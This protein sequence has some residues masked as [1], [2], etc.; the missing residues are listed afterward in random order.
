VNPVESYI[1]GNVNSKCKLVMLSYMLRRNILSLVDYIFDVAI[2]Y[3]FQELL[4][5]E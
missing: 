3:C 5:G 4:K 1:L 2:A